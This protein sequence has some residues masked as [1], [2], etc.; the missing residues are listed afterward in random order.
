MKLQAC[1]QPEVQRVQSNAETALFRKRTASAA[2]PNNRFA[3]CDETNTQR[4]GSVNAIGCVETREPCKTATRADERLQSRW[5]AT[6]ARAGPR[7]PASGA[8]RTTS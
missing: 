3:K 1:A 2:G 7:P 4:G 6:A 8:R 5:P